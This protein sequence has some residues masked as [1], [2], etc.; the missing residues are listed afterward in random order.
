MNLTPAREEIDHRTIKLIVGL[1]AVSLGT[2]TAHFAYVDTGS[3]IASISESYYVGG[4]SQSFFVGCLFAIGAFL[5]A[6][7]G[8]TFTE[9]VLSKIASF[10]AVGV[11][12][13]PCQCNNELE[14]IP[15]LHAAAAAAMFIVLACFCYIFFRRARLKGHTQANMRAGIYALCGIAMILSLLVLAFDGI[16]GGTLTEKI[17]RLTFYG[18]HTGLIAFGISWLTASRVLPF[19]T[20]EDERFSLLTASASK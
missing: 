9:M 10:A 4:W 13:F 3:D 12:L 2:L 14:I 18:E 19:I 16:S 20:R 15:H 1:I 5:M 6:Y 7:N 11:A 8:L 17:P